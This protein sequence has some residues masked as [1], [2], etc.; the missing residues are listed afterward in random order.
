LGLKIFKFRRGFPF[1][2][3]PVPRSGSP[4][5][6]PVPVSRFRFP[7]AVFFSPFSLFPHAGAGGGGLRLDFRGGNLKVRSLG[8]SLGPRS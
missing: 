4:F 6:V 3:F 1:S 8:P 5:P 2:P 7:V